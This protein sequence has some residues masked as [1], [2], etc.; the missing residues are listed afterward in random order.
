M[1][2]VAA[3]L[4]LILLSFFLWNN[5]SVSSNSWSNLWFRWYSRYHRMSTADMLVKK[6]LHLRRQMLAIF[7]FYKLLCD[8]MWSTVYTSLALLLWSIPSINCYSLTFWCSTSVS[9]TNNCAISLI[10]NLLLCNISNIS[11]SLQLI[12]H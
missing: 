6:R 7:S 3:L 5:K 9:C 10:K 2:T 11:F 12:V 8:C 1:V 4:A